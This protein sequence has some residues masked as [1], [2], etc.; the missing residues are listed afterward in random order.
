MNTKTPMNIVTKALLASAALLE[1]NTRLYDPLLEP[2]RS[3]SNRSWPKPRLD[4]RNRYTRGEITADQFSLALTT[5]NLWHTATG[6]WFAR[7]QAKATPG[8]KHP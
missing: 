7:Q 2:R 5:S 1:P 8:Q 4:L 3:T 6:K